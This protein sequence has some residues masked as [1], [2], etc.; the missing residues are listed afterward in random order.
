MGNTKGNFDASAHMPNIEDSIQQ[1]QTARRAFLRRSGRKVLDRFHDCTTSL[2]LA[3]VGDHHE[4]PWIV[5]AFA[6]FRQALI[7]SE[8]EEEQAATTIFRTPF[9]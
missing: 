3:F 5:A 6:S 2:Y 7:A 1:W 8:P 9:L 4:E